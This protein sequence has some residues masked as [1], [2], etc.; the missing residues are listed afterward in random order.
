MKGGDFLHLLKR[1]Q[2][3]FTQQ[4]VC[5]IISSLALAVSHLHSFGIVHRDLKP[6]NILLVDEN[7]D[8]PVKLVDFGLS[9]ILGPNEKVDDFVGKKNIWL[10]KIRHTKIFSSRSCFEIK[11]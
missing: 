8:S 4:R 7:P 9:K 11:I 6:E 1:M 3:P 5:Q 10:I 2:S